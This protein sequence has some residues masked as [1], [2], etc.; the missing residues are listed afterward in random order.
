MQIFNKKASKTLC[1]IA[2]FPLLL[3]PL[4][5]HTSSDGAKVICS[6]PQA[7]LN[8]AGVKPE[9]IALMSMDEVLPDCTQHVTQA[10]IKHVAY[11]ES[12]ISLQSMNFKW[13]ET[14][15]TVL[16]NIGENAALTID[17]IRSASQFIQVGKSYLMHFQ[18]CQG[19]SPSLIS[20]YT[21]GNVGLNT[22]KSKVKVTTKSLKSV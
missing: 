16:T 18:L 17:E 13:H 20:M 7:A 11:S 6:S 19:A 3:N 12:G 8:K 2:L 10:K 4:F 1:Q 15:T 9:V 22:K 5:G 21:L 14:D